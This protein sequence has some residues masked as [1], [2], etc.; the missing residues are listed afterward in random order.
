MT[1][2]FLS[3]GWRIP[4]ATVGLPCQLTFNIHIAEDDAPV[5][6][7]WRLIVAPEAITLEQGHAEHAD[8]LF[9]MNR[10]AAEAVLDAGEPTGPPVEQIAGR[11]V[12]LGDLTQLE[13][14]QN[15]I[16]ATEGFR[17][18]ARFLAALTVMAWRGN[19]GE[20]AHPSRE[21]WWLYQWPADGRPQLTLAAGDPD[22]QT[23][24]LL[25]GS[26]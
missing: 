24:R 13:I 2:R 9:V 26:V 16:S 18:A 1:A 4:R 6:E 20:G 23:I 15:E 22:D 12:A 8:A 10:A 21:Q 3:D 11:V 5:S 7:P 19:E 14:A 25:R 17:W